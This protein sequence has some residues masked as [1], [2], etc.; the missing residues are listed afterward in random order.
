VVGDAVAGAA[1]EAASGAESGCTNV[2]EAAVQVFDNREGGG[3]GNS[4]ATAAVDG[5]EGGGR[6]RPSGHEPTAT[7]VVGA[8]GHATM[9]TNSMGTG[10]ASP[11]DLDV[12]GGGGAPEVAAGDKP[13]ESN[14]KTAAAGDL[15]A[16]PDDT[17]LDYYDSF[18]NVS[19]ATCPTCHTKTLVNQD[20]QIPGQP[21]IV[22]CSNVKCC[23]T[24]AVTSFQSAAAAGGRH[25]KTDAEK[26]AEAA[27]KARRARPFSVDLRTLSAFK[28]STPQQQNY[29]DCALFMMQY[30][31]LFLRLYG[32]R[33]DTFSFA[34]V[35]SKCRNIGIN[36]NWFSVADMRNK[37]AALRR[38][39]LAL[40]VR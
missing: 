9:D 12:A 40:Q 27:A 38:E 31:E 34:E 4:T 26:A 3:N 19:T 39:L 33:P 16:K 10:G 24:M 35:L 29:V 23:L 14:G 13:P 15:A 1:A 11:T 2:I 20:L 7:A 36:S 6:G 17:D 5:E 30:L 32:R 21:Y 8:A 28:V 22:A 25:K 37:R 18:V